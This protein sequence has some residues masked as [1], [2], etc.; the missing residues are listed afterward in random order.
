MT[1]NK[2]PAQKNDFPGVYLSELVSLREHIHS[3]ANKVGLI[4]VYCQSFSIKCKDN[5]DKIP[6]LI[7]TELPA[8]ESYY[9][10]TLDYLSSI[11]KM[12][13][14]TVASKGWADIEES[15][16]DGLKDIYKLLTAARES[17]SKVSGPNFKTDIINISKEIGKFHEKCEYMCNLIDGIKP[18]LL[19]LGI[20]DNVFNEKGDV[21]TK[22]L[23]CDYDPEINNSYKEWFEERGYAVCTANNGEDAIRTV[24]YRK[25]NIVCLDVKL[26][27]VS[28]LEVL[29]SIRQK[30]PGTKVIMTTVWS[31]EEVKE[32]LK[33]EGLF[34][35][36][37]ITKPLLMADLEKKV[38][39][40]TKQG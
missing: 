19:S 38:S 2:I 8:I 26:H 18:E 1:K 40:L 15:I 17:T 32:K 10:I 7:K 30:N 33:A 3:L 4:S 24:E 5:P 6:D 11:S 12:L 25:P 20:Y 16:K 27:A 39:A 37:Y 31:N 34:A 23:F 29:K 22:I 36:D 14:K 35:D 9:K 21:M 13:A 28:E